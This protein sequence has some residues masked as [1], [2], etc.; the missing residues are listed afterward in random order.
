MLYKICTVQIQPR[1]HGLDHADYTAPPQKHELLIDHTDQEPTD[2][3]P[4][5]QRYLDHQ[6]GIDHTDHLSDVCKVKV[7]ICLLY[8]SP[9][10]RD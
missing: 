3:C 7:S 9:S 10:P 2:I 5:R 4:G 6:L 8:T 1:K